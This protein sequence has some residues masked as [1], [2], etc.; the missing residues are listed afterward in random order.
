MKIPSIQM[1]HLQRY[2][3]M[4]IE[5]DVGECAGWNMKSG[6]LII[7][8]DA[9]DYLGDSMDNGTIEVFGNAGEN[10]GYMGTGGKIIVHGDIKNVHDAVFNDTKIYHGK[11]LI[12]AK[13]GF[14]K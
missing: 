4:T 2:V 12:W 3:H 1:S 14:V 5:G 10:I 13:G 6:K 8:G 7:K 11:N 9:G